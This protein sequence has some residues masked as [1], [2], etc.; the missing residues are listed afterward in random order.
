MGSATGMARPEFAVGRDMWERACAPSRTGLAVKRT[1]DLV[2]A[3]VGL[4]VAAP[5]GVLIAVAIR[6]ASPGPVIFR[7]TRVGRRGKTFSML[8]FRTMVDGAEK[9]RHEL[10]ARNESDGI[11]KLKDDPRLTEIGRLLRRCSLDELPQLV[12]VL[13][14]EMSLVGPRPLVVSED[15]RVQGPHRAR[16]LMR[17]GLTGPWQAIGPVRPPLREMVVIDRLYVENWSL[18]TDVRILLQTL[19]HVARMRGV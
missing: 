14:G 7:Q 3:G 9:A 11:F 8:K 18:W 19:V 1:L 17:P 12:N 13:R 10:E 2:I 15:E 5:L 6:C 4:V 16:L